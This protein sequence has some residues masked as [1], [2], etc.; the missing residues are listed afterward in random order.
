MLIWPVDGRSRQIYPSGLRHCDSQ[1]A[2]VKKGKKKKTLVQPINLAEEGQHVESVI[3]G[4][5]AGQ[6]RASSARNQLLVIDVRCV[7]RRVWRQTGCISSL[8]RL[9]NNPWVK[10]LRCKNVGLIN[11]PLKMIYQV[12]GTVFMFHDPKVS[13]NV[14]ND[15]LNFDSNDLKVW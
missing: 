6:D 7:R 15:E 4:S 1:S 9:F 8:R 3:G 12:I 10:L 13:L 11:H 5:T 14:G 2:A